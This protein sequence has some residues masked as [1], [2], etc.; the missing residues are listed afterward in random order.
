M[1]DSNQKKG[2]D[3]ELPALGEIS[4]NDSGDV[5]GVTQLLT[6]SLA[7]GRKKQEISSSLPS[8]HTPD[9]P[10]EDP[11]LVSAEE[12][13]EDLVIAEPVAPSRATLDSL[14]KTPF[15]SWE[16]MAREI[17]VHFEL[18]FSNPGS[19]YEFRNYVEHSSTPLESWRNE[20]YSGMKVEKQLLS[21]V[22]DFQEVRVKDE[23][24]LGE[25]FGAN[26]EDHLLFI[27]NGDE[28]KV[29]LS[30]NSLMEHRQE[31]QSWLTQKTSASQ[32]SAPPPK[33]PPAVKQDFDPGEDDGIKIEIA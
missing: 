16:T 11:V 7:K 21:L 20:F 15:P 19:V 17:G 22:S 29:L 32:K 8:E 30:K 26:P 27:A 23:P 5:P 9:V 24:F 13:H 3:V 1:A 10:Q 18:A 12:V 2:D 31:I 14:P 6:P 28:L 33:Q 4:F 25:C